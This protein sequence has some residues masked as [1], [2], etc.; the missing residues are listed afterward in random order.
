MEPGRIMTGLYI[1][2]KI[3]ALHNDELVIVLRKE[4]YYV[5]IWY[6]DIAFRS[7]ADFTKT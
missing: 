3:F 5:S 7:E 4:K 2:R 6:E 1:F